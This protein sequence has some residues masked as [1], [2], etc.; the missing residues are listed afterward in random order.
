MFFSLSNFGIAYGKKVIT[1]L[2]SS[3]AVLPIFSFILFCNLSCQYFV[4]RKPG[5]RLPRDSFTQSP[6]KASV[7]IKLSVVTVKIV[8]Y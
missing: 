3:P 5:V 7:L 1:S 4:C 2:N 8:T 6:L